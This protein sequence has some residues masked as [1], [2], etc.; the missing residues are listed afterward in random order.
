MKVHHPRP[1]FKAVY[2]RR[3]L[4]LVEMLVVVA[5]IGVIAALCI[6]VLGG[7]RKALVE[8]RDRRNAQE[9]ASLCQA[10]KAAGVELAVADDPVL[11]AQLA[12]T[13]KEAEG[14]AFDG[15]TFKLPGLADDDVESAAF[16]LDV[17]G[18]EVTYNGSR[19]RP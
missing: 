13:G 9:I 1:S 7:Q 17:V 10:A 4:S 19:R 2:S 14:G 6:M 8:A 5:I 16:F 15:K 12:V 3:G 11:T 18:M